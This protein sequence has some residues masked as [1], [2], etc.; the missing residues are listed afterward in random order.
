MHPPLKA[1]FRIRARSR[2]SL[3]VLAALTLAGAGPTHALRYHIH[4]YTQSD[5][6][7]SGAV[8]DVAQSADGRMWFATRA[9]IVCYD[10]R[11]WMLL[12][13][14]SGLPTIDQYRLFVDDAGHIWTVGREARC[15]VYNG[16]TWTSIE[17]VPY[18]HGRPFNDHVAAITN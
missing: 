12:D 16:S 8:Q 6:L 4:T 10:G 11:E 5:G 13:A 18:Q 3:L 15:A 9:G 2:A 14:A 1:F 17:G 7:P